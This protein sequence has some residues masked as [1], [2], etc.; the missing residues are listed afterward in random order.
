MPVETQ[1]EVEQIARVVDKKGNK[2]PPA[3]DDF[4]HIYGS[5]I[6]LSGGYSAATVAPDRAST[7]TIH[8]EGWGANGGDV[9]LHTLDPDGNRITTRTTADNAAYGSASGEDVM[10]EA[11]VTS[12]NLEIEI[13]GDGPV[14]A[15][16]YIQ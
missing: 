12:P 4:R 10:V 9:A 3:S 15:S 8:V 16:I 5:G 11:A 1:T 6:D 7:I 13:T 14:N 2:K